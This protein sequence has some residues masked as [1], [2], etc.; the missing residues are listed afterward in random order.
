MK[1][2]IRLYRLLMFSCFIISCVTME[3]K[4]RNLPWDNGK[5]MVSEENRYLKHENGMPFFGLEILDGYCPNVLI[6][7]RLPF[8]AELP[9]CWI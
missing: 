6:V 2:V 5:L 3:G 9:R 1:T 4:S 7:M 8:I